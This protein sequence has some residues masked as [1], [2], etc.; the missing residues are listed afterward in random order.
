MDHIHRLRD[1]FFHSAQNCVLHQSDLGLIQVAPE[2][3]ENLE[4][5]S[6]IGD[7]GLAAAG[8]EA[9]HNLQEPFQSQDCRSGYKNFFL[10]KITKYQLKFIIFTLESLTS[11]SQVGPKNK[12]L[13]TSLTIA[14]TN[15]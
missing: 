3:A 4:Q 12:A 8:V 6:S 2:E 10:L 7:A 5:V 15:L 11:F 13:N 14:R 1:V 9:V